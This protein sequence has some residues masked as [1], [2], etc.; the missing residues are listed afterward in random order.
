[1]RKILAALFLLF[2][3]GHS[4]KAV[5]FKLVNKKLRSI[6]LEIPG[7]MNPNLSPLSYSG[8]DLKVG[9]KI[10][11]YFRGERIELLEVKDSL[12]GQKINVAKRIKEIIKES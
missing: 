4:S 10:Y 2:C 6:K 8:V 3:L 7:V 11:F 12:Q 5:P 1:M 9:Q